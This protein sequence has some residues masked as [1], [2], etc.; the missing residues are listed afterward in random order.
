MLNS[1]AQRLY[2]L[3][4]GGGSGAQVIEGL[5]VPV[6]FSNGDQVIAAPD[7]YVVK[8]ATIKKPDT[9]IPENIAKDIDIAGIVG[10]Y[11]GS[12]VGAG[13]VTVTFMNGD[14][15]IFQR[16]VYIGDDCPDPV[17]QGRFDTPT[18]ESTAQYDYTFSG[19][20]LTDGGSADGTALLNITAD[21]TLY[22]AFNA[23][24]RYYTVNFYDGDTLLK[25]EQ[26]AY[27]G[28][29][30]YEYEKAG[31]IFNGWTPE[32]TNITGDISCYGEWKESKEIADS[33]DEIIAA[34]DDGTYASKYE[35]GQYKPLD[36]GTEGIINMQIVGIDI[37]K[38]ADNETV[39]LSFVAKEL[40]NTQY[41]INGTND[42]NSHYTNLFSG[43]ELKAYLDSTIKPLFPAS[44][45]TGIKSVKKT[46]SNANNNSD[47]T[48]TLDVWIPSIYEIGFTA[49][50]KNTYAEWNGVSYAGIYNSNE[51]RIKYK[52]ND[53]ATVTSW[54][55]RTGCYNSG[56]AA[57]VCHPISTT[58]TAGRYGMSTY[59]KYGICLGFCI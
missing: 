22:A 12:G 25:T 9:L 35:I 14:E 45:Q 23:A 37:D 2:S 15:V 1:R 55:T 16:P 39:G 29:S 56:M 13:C 42:S 49:G 58:G 46:M 19:W 53:S 50:V 51:S 11:A 7:G 6:D 57:T 38:N 20:S 31:Y 26:I 52:A 10:S 47:T 27:N 21:K 18:K 41:Q 4:H 44:L 33:W 54:W 48:Q 28:S 5:D 24:V 40:L 32:P 34:V 3:T 8:S 30:S 17:S 59:H 43:S 36:L